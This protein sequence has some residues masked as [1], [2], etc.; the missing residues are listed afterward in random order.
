MKSL[1]NHKEIN[2]SFDNNWAIVYAAENGNIRILETLIN[3]KRFNPSGY[4]NYAV[5]MASHNGNIGCVRLLLEDKGLTLPKKVVLVLSM[6]LK[7]NT[8]M[9][10]IYCGKISALKIH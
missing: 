1:I 8:M 4:R 3:N 6:P 9:L 5:F 10:L 2:P 7:I